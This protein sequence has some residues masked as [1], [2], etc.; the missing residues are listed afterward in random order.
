MTEKIILSEEQSM[1]IGKLLKDNGVSFV[2]GRAGTGKTTLI[3]HFR[4]FYKKNLIVLAP[5]GVAALNVNG[6]TI[7]RF[8]RFPI[9]LDDDKFAKLIFDGDEYV[10]L[11]CIVIDE[12]SMVRCDILDY[13]DK[14]LKRSKNNNNPFGG[15]QI[16]MVGDLYQLPPVVDYREREYFKEVYETEYFFSSKVLSE[17]NYSIY[18]LSNIY[19]QKDLEFISILNG[20]R[21]GTT[22]TKHLQRLNECIGKIIT[23]EE[24][25]YVTLCSL[26][27]IATSINYQKLSEI[28]EQELIFEARITGKVSSDTYPTNPKLRLKVGSQIML[29]KNDKDRQ[30]YNGSIG[31]ILEFC[32]IDEE[33][34]TEEYSSNPENNN[35]L[36]VKIR[37]D[38]DSVIYV[39]RE[40]WDIEDI[41]Y[42]KTKKKLVYNKIGEFEQYPI[43]LAWAIS[44]H[45]SQGK[46]FTNIS[47]NLKGGLFASGQLYVGLS[48]CT[49]LQGLTLED[50]IEEKH[51]RF[52]WRVSKYFKNFYVREAEKLLSYEAKKEIVTL[53]IPK[54]LEIE[55]KYLNKNNEG[56]FRRILPHRFYLTT[57]KSAKYWALDAYCFKRQEVRT[58]QIARILNIANLEDILK[59]L[60]IKTG[61]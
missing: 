61:N 55:I 22:T 9:N 18:E 49:T 31:T 54:K 14:F 57:F 42:D 4:N 27:K 29:V 19:R 35:K 16:I 5:T 34:E 58:F 50:Q 37:L 20:I 7:H 47:I 48:R 26:R 32:Y 6:K 36:L 25:I 46:T 8:F 23:N 38:N 45:K 52:D 40:V 15:I 2:T 41:V 24:D 56:S 39:G 43:T 10:E 30:W 60:D 11:D 59:E 44:I 28:P 21:N 53:C 1:L 17:N 51:I 13:V 12:I 33:D 3:D